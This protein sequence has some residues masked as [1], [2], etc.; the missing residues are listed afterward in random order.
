MQNSTVQV[1]VNHLLYIR[2]EESIFPLKPVLINLFEPFK[3]VFNTLV[4]WGAL[5]FALPIDR[6]WDEYRRL[7]NKIVKAVST[8]ILMPIMIEFRPCSGKH[9]ILYYVHQPDTNC[10]ISCN[11]AFCFGQRSCLKACALMHYFPEYVYGCMSNNYLIINL[12]YRYRFFTLK[13]AIVIYFYDYRWFL[14]TNNK[15]SL[16]L[17]HPV[18]CPF[19]SL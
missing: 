14:L 18:N 19:L 5:G 7:S 17:G 10:N 16:A 1:T 6:F 4:I 11:I 12:G 9:H 2:T 3:I 15:Y 13:T 8:A